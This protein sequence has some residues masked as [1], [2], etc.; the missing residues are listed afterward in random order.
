MNK[1]LKIIR[2]NSV[3]FLIICIFSIASFQTICANDLFFDLKTGENLLNCGFDFK[4]HFSWIPDLTYIYLHWFYDIIIY[5][6]YKIA[7]YDGL[8]VFFLSIFMFFSLLYY[9][10]INKHINNK[11]VST[12][13]SIIM[14]YLCN[15]AFVTRV[16]SIIY[17]LMFLE[18]VLLEKLY[19]NG[20]RKYSLYLLII[21]LLVVNLQM[22]IWILFTIIFVPYILEILFYM[23]QQRKEF[24]NP[25]KFEKPKNAKLFLLT[26]CAILLSGLCSPLTYYSYIYCFQTLNN[27]IYTLIN[28]G[29]MQPTK[30]IYTKK[31]LIIHIL[32]YIGIYL[33]KLKISFRDFCLILGLFVFSLIVNKNVIFYIFII[34]YI[35]IKTVNYQS[36]ISCIEKY[37]KRVNR[38]IV[39]SILFVFLIL[40]LLLVLYVKYNSFNNYG[41]EYYPVG[42]ADY[43]IDNTDYKNIRLYTDFNNGS[44][45]AFRDIPVFVDSRAEVYIAD[46]NGGSDVLLDYIN[47]SDIEYSEELLTKYDFDY[48]SIPKGTKFHYI[49]NNDNDYILI[50]SYHEFDLFKHIENEFT[51]Y[52]KDL[53]CLSNNDS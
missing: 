48:L 44:Y 41:I 29:E 4:D 6:I 36:I 28:I 45:Y 52:D 1:F 38:P 53:H 8:F 22:P 50:Y 24:L 3:P 26:F 34:C 19:K 39:N 14:I 9:F 15:Y 20:D 47:L 7:S 17:L 27:P 32:L 30:L 2:N 35:L 12:V 16:Q 25:F 18:I 10:C 42:I 13:F 33:H 40:C 11:I 51:S 21:S 31:V 43:L 5:S 46:F 37:L 23:L 49:I